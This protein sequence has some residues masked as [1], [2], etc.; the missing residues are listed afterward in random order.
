[1]YGYEVFHE[2]ILKTLI[3]SL[4]EGHTQHA[5]IFEGD[6]GI[7]K[8][9]AAALFSAALV[10]ENPALAPCGECPACIGAKANTNPDIKYINSGDKKSIGVEV[11]REIVA[12]A[13]VRPFESKKKVYIIENGGLITEQAQNSF[14]KILEEPPE[15]TVFI[16]LVSNLSM[17][18]QTIISRC[19]HIRFMPLKKDVIE[20]YIKSHYPEA[21]IRFLEKYSE[22]NPGKVDE[23][24][25]NDRFFPLRLSALKHITPL[26]SRHR[27]S[28]F[29][30]ADFLEENKEDSS[31]IFEFWQSFLRDIIFIQNDAK[32]SIIDS[33]LTDELE[34][35][36]GKIP[37]QLCFTAANYLNHAADMQRR[38][39]NLRAIA[40]Y[41]SLS[42][43]KEGKY[44]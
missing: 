15:Y 24:M 23:I 28:A 4:K 12:D 1:M 5:Y 32:A 35:L 41:L 43:K 29:K 34:M 14:L 38:Y 40:L 33:D 36:A 13:Y 8:K 25:N 3:S 11:M 9:K 6:E 10:C 16:I 27:I 39:V 7:G 31:L 21:D 42:I 26:L 37:H 44:N 18:L 20:N 30:I 2:D 22:G 19:T 17:L